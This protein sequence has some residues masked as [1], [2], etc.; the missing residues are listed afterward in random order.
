[1]ALEI[2]QH[3]PGKDMKEFIRFPHKLFKD[4]PNWIAPLNFEVKERLTPGK[5]PFFEHGEVTLFTAWE[6]GEVVG[7]ISAQIDQ[8][9]LKRYQD[10]TGFFGFFDTIEDEAV[11]RT[12]VATASDWLGNKGM[13]RIRGP[14]S[15]SMNE[16]IGTLVEGFDTPPM[17]MM[18]H[19]LPY[20]GRMAEV[21]GLEKARDVFAWR[22][23]ITK[24]KPRALKAL[25]MINQ[26]PEVH[27]RNIRRAD[28]KQE[29]K[30]LLEIYND[31]WSNNW[32]YV[33]TTASE[34]EKVAEDLKLVIDEKIGFFVEIN[35]E[36]AAV[37]LAFPN[38]NE[39]ARDIHGK[40]FPLG[41]FKLIWRLKVKQPK[42]ARLVFLGI[43]E[44]FRNTK[45]YGPLAM[46][47]V[48]EI[49][50]RGVK[51]GYEYA[52]LSWTLEDNVPV[53]LLIRSMGCQMYKR[54]RIYEKSI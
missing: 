33:P 48:A 44:K 50:Q 16:E 30:I 41:L 6:N 36:P 19:A 37:C 12:L 32:G 20:Q 18:G 49:A 29:L 17:L 51:E 2:R 9:H 35:G 26:L 3:T 34:A 8:E 5:N 4:D 11:A 45:R 13:K 22:Y 7:R 43:K 52:E 10:S 21:A 15:L 46:A 42:T 39:A 28:L 54:Y 1:M 47:I 23:D 40:L 38:L 27:F 14:L 31:A 53:N 24:V 25:E